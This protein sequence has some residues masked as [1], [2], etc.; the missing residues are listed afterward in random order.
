MTNRQLYSALSLFS[1][2][3]ISIPLFSQVPTI[4]RD[5]LI[6]LYDSTDGENWTNNTNWGTSEPVSTWFG[7]TVINDHVS[8][9]QL[10]YKGLNGVLPSEIGDLVYL[11]SLKIANN[12]D[13][14]GEIPSEIGNLVNLLELNLSGNTLTGSIPEGI[15]NASSLFNLRLAS[16]ELEDS[17]PSSIWEL[18]QLNHIRFNSNNLIGNIPPEISNLTNLAHLDLGYN[19]FSGEIPSEI[20]ELTSMTRIR[21]SSNSFEDSIP[22]EIG[23]LTE[24]IELNLSNNDL[25][26]PIP[27][28]LGNL[29]NLNY[30][31]M[32]GNDLTGNIPSEIWDL[33][34]LINL[35]IAW[36]QLEGTLPTTVSNLGNI[37]QIWLNNNLFSG[38]IPSEFGNLGSLEILFLDNNE[39]EGTLPYELTYLSTLLKLGVSNNLFD[40][41]P[42]FSGLTN[43]TDLWAQ[44]NALE[45]DDL[46]PHIELSNFTYSPQANIA[47][48]D[49]IS[50]IEGEELSFSIPVGGSA[51]N[52]QWYKDGSA[53]SGQTSDTFF[54]ES[55][56]LSDA[57]T[58]FLEITN[59]LVSDLTL[60]TENIIVD[61]TEDVGSAIEENR[62]NNF[63]LYPNPTSGAVNIELNANYTE[64][65]V[66]IYTLDCRLLQS[67]RKEN[68]KLLNLEISQKQGIYFVEVNADNESRIF[69][70][71]IE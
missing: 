39:F 7:V 10:I 18:D 3:L 40:S 37:E 30:F 69:K 50:I 27:S 28:S 2:L 35:V 66:N 22:S 15:G 60:Q 13:L 67:E 19:Q 14:S 1:I 59:D 47:G 45:F 17:I 46:E 33:P 26:G 62:N 42:D 65:I 16:N 63:K 25:I 41:I 54:I 64:V 56:A 24:L 43:M 23:N 51:N 32:S 44:S 11:T 20:G 8:T 9:L 34:N 21:F 36:N 6:A 29:I 48:L 61:V 57:G 38:S 71:I 53:I 31:L 5:A 58:Y 4:E 55:S 70:L 49:P 52:Y 12:A 68:I